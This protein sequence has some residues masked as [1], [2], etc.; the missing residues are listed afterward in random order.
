MFDGVRMEEI[1]EVSMGALSALARDTQNKNIIQSQQVIPLLAQL[2]LG[3]NANIT[4][5]A[6]EVLCELTQDKRDVTFW[7]GLKL[8]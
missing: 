5:V 2:M 4:R 8:I 6:A 3:N 1:V 7:C